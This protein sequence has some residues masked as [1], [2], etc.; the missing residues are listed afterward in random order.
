MKDMGKAL[1]DLLLM[2]REEL[3]ENPKAEENLGDSNCVMVE[4]KILREEKRGEQQ[5]KD[6]GPQKSRL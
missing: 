5:N 1:L 4:F 2:D 3:V 6:T